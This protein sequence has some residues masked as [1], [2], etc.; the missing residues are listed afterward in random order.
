[1]PPKYRP[2]LSADAEASKGNRMSFYMAQLSSY[3]KRLTTGNVRCVVADGDYAKTR[4]F[5]TAEEAGCHLVT[6]LRSDANLRYIYKG[7]QKSGRGAPKRYDGKVD[8]GDLARFEK[9]GQ[10]PD[11][12]HVD[13]YTQTLNSPHFKRNLRVVVLVDTK[14]ETYVLL[15]CSDPELEAMKIVEYYRLQ[16]QIELIFRDV[17]QFIDL[18]HCQARSKQKL[19]FHLNTSLMAVSLAQVSILRAKQQISMNTFIRRAHN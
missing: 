5:E 14:A 11:H 6:K 7:P 1:V 3:L 4:V 10:L 12:S 17:K 13:V 9:V 15:G 19:D 8:F 16:F 18:T 2:G